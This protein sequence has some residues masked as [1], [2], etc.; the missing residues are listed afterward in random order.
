MENIEEIKKRVEKLREE[1]EYHS[2]KYYV[3]DQPEISDYDYD[4]M[5]NELIKLEEEYPELK[6]PT[7]PTQRVGGA[8]LKEFNQV[9]HSVPMLS[10]QDVFSFEELKNWVNKIKEVYSEAEF[11]VELKI[12][13]L[14]V[15]LLYE[16]GELIR[17]ATRGDGNIG[18]DV[19]NN[20]KTIKSIPLKIKDKN[21]L[22][23][24]G[25]VYMPKAAFIKLNE[26][27]EELSEQTFANPR[28]AAAG[29]LRQLDP[30]ITAKR[31]LDIF[32]FNIQR[33]DGE[34][35]THREGLDYLE[36]LGFKVSPKRILCKDID[37]IINAIELL[38]DMRGELTFDI[39]GIVIK[40]N[41]LKMR[42]ELGQTAKTPRWAVAYKFP[43]E[44]KVTK[45]VDIVLQV[46][47]TGA[48][49]PTA[50]LE[51]VRIAGSVVSRATL[52][53]EDY[54]K[55]KDIMI[56]DTVIIQKAGEII[57]EV[58]EVVKEKR[59]GSEVVFNMPSK[60]P[61]CGAD[62]V[63]EEGEA[64]LRCTNISCPAQIKRSIIHFASR[65]AMN[66]E[67]LGPQMVSLL[68]DNNLIKDA[69]D[70]Y[71]LKFEDIVNLERMGDK[72]AQNL[73]NA[74]NKSRE[75][76]IDRLI[77]G[78][79][80]RFVGLKGAKNVGRHFKSIDRL[81]E[82]KYEDLVEVEEVGDKMA[83]SILEFFKQEQNLNLIKKLKDAGVNFQLKAQDT[84][85]NKIF[86]GKTFALTGTLNNYKRSDVQKIIEDRGGKV[87]SSVSKKTDFVLAGAEAGS[88]LAKAAE[89]NVKI[90]SEEEFQ[91]MISE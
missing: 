66:I 31:K 43:A 24:R 28:N 34:I 64:A 38:G 60:C 49:T 13:G 17:G 74:I 62:A 80:I 20:I 75:N 67:G 37:E 53:N 44:R 10:L 59:N 15:S 54:I 18:E 40:V 8:P 30:K 2:Y 63:R 21:L 91:K 4:R 76:D 87:S 33:Y 47:R 41:D 39:D 52:H 35:K 27:K 83:N 46:G 69:S 23:V 56:G 55:D 7:S 79:G 82:A 89:L 32:V 19:T 9:V 36:T 3:L 78:L 51:P 26:K 57:P 5:M 90:I 6:S 70:L 1:L 29:S 86:E 12:D 81:K 42:E 45:L 22:E 58:V 71:Y 77:F 25:E 61:V 14:S 16:N 65:N 85:I 11:V 88:K 72:S 48:I 73:L 68:I 84:E 50:V